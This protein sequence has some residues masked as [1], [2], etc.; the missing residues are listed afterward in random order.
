[1]GLHGDRGYRKF[2]PNPALAHRGNEG[3][4]GGYDEKDMLFVREKID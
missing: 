4:G 1:V 3:M 2:Y